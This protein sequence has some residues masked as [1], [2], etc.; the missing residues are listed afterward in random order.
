MKVSVI[1]PVYNEEKYVSDC[2]DSL[3]EQTQT[4]EI[5]VIDDGSTDKT[6]EIL[7]RYIKKIKILKQNHLG[8]A[9][10]RNLGAKQSSGDILVF[11]D[12]DMEFEN[13]FVK[14]LIR[15]I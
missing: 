13:D 14:Q 12:A 4:L 9:V 10:A 6:P 7:D 11:A 15:P 2:L 1:I 3:L 5:I 8:P